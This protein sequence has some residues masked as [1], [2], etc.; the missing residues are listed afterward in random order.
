MTTPRYVQTTC[1]WCGSP[2]AQIENTDYLL[3]GR[4]RVASCPNC[5]WIREFDNRGKEDETD[6]TTDNPFGLDNSDNIPF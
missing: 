3:E 1:E 2:E 6:K 5:D 4:F